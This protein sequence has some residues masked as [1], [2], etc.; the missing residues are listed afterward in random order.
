MWTYAYREAIDHLD[1]GIALLAHLPESPERTQQELTLQVG[2]SLS[3]MHTRGFADPEVEHAYG[4]VR[5]LSH[6]VGDSPQRFAA[7]WGLRNFHLLRGELQAGCAAAQ[8]FLELVRR[9]EMS[10]LAAE[11]H[12]GLGTPLFHLGEFGAAR[13]HIEQSLALYNPR[14]PQPKVFLT[15]QDP[16]ASSLA[17]LAVLL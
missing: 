15:G 12:L 11:A 7:L 6:T 8:E 4:R 10:S 2:R 13:P 1:K 16:R 3:L 5:D 14:L 9:T 17:H